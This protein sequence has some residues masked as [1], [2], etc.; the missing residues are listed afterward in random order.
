MMNDTNKVFDLSWLLLYCKSSV[1]LHDCTEFYI[2][3]RKTLYPSVVLLCSVIVLLS[4][5][6]AD[7]GTLSPA[8]IATSA[9][10]ES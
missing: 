8:R 10:P 5:P 1:V 7:R 3:L 4:T 6:Q 9:S 2:Y